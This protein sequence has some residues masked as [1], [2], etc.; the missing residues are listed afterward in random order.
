MGIRA[1]G[2][3]ENFMRARLN[4]KD[5]NYRYWSTV[6]EQREKKAW[7]HVQGTVAVPGA[8]L[9]LGASATPAIPAVPAII[10][11]MGV[12]PVAGVAAF[13]ANAGNT[14]VQVDASRVVHD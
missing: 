10:A 14:Q 4:L 7:G 13:A 12:A 9:I 2:D 8:I 5:G 1:N 11:A 6:L 3:L